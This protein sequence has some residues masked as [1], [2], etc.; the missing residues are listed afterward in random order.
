MPTESSPSARP[1][2]GRALTGRSPR[3]ARPI[4]IEEAPPESTGIPA[5]PDAV[6]VGT[7]HGSALNRASYEA[8]AAAW[9]ATRRSFVLREREYLETLLRGM[10]AGARVLDLGCGSGRPIAEYSSRGGIG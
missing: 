1:V 6:W 3:S 5:L 8:I 2:L 7:G 10:A 9:H 4:V